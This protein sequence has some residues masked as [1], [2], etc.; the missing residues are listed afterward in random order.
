MPTP[1]DHAVAEEWL[2]PSVLCV[3][4]KLGP[5]ARKI[6]DYVASHR[7]QVMRKSTLID[8][9]VDHD[10]DEEAPSEE[11]ASDAEPEGGA[12]SARVCT[13]T[14]E[15]TTTPRLLRYMNR[16]NDGL[17]DV[18]SAF[19]DRYQHYSHV[20]SITEMHIVSYASGHYRMELPDA[21]CTMLAIVL[22]TPTSGEDLRIVVPGVPD[23][24]LRGEPGDVIVIPSGP[25]HPYEIVARDRSTPF[26]YV[27]TQLD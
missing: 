16:L 12:R 27:H 26:E 19:I 15:E 6:C 23:V 10:D 4:S 9:A 13:V 3:R 21:T 14:M 24:W 22:L 7:E 20:S 25:L 17:D 8:S 18:I 2:T 11:S 1:A 5:Q